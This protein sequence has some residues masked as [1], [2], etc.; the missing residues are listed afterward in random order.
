MGR[1]RDLKQ[2][3]AV[4]NLYRHLLPGDL[5]FD[6]RTYLHECKEAGDRGSDQGDYTHAELI[7]KLRE[8][9]GMEE[10]P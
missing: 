10:L 9:L 4:C 6:Y 2:V 1:K 5:E 7:E 8:F 3:D